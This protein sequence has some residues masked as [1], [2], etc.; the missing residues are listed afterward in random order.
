MGQQSDHAYHQG[1]PLLVGAHDHQA[2]PT[3]R[4]HVQGG[5]RQECAHYYD[6]RWDAGESRSYQDERPG[7]VDG[8]ESHDVLPWDTGGPREVVV[9]CGHQVDQPCYGE[10]DEL[11][12][13]EDP[14]EVD[15]AVG[16]APPPN[17]NGELTEQETDVPIPALVGGG[18]I[19]KS[20]LCS[21]AARRFL[22][23]T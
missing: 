15:V 4:A 23:R 8:C 19:A 2:E 20:R 3:D 12:Q 9:S 10:D 7:V 17:E 14:S 16:Q 1:G 18:G 13:Y 21:M 5:V 11:P 22:L 6:L